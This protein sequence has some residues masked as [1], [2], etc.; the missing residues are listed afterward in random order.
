RCKRCKSSSGNSAYAAYTSYASGRLARGAEA[1]ASVFLGRDLGGPVAV[2]EVPV[3]GFLDAGGERL[4][5][6]PAKLALDLR[7]IDCVAAVVAGAVGDVGDLIGVFFA[8]GT[9]GLLVEQRADRTDDLEVRLLVQAADVVGL[10]DATA[11][12]HEPDRGGVVLDEEPVA[13][14]HAV[15]VD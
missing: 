13:D 5:R 12:E 1:F 14:L 6:G 7:T 8:V 11:L 4:A 2:G 10:A 3:D 9:R 15:A